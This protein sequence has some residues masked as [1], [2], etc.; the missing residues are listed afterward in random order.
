MILDTAINFHDRRNSTAQR[1]HQSLLMMVFTIASHRCF[2][3][4]FRQ[5]KSWSVNAFGGNTQPKRQSLYRANRSWT[6]VTF[7]VGTKTKSSLDLTQIPVPVQISRKTQYT[8]DDSVCR[9]TNVHLLK[10]VV[11]KACRS[12]P[13]YLHNKP[14]A[15]H[16]RQAFDSLL[17]QLLID[18]S[19]GDDDVCDAVPEVILSTFP[20]GIILD[21]GC[22]T[23]RSTRLLAPMYPHHLIL[24]ID[25]SIA[26]LMKSQNKK[27]K[28][29]Q[30][31]DDNQ[32]YVHPVASNA[33][34][35]RAELV[36]FWRCCLDHDERFWTNHIS[37]HYLL[38]PN[39]YPTLQRL[40]LRWYAH[41]S[42][43]LLLQLNAQRL[44]VRSN[45]EEYLKEFCMAVEIA[46]DYYDTRNDSHDLPTSM[47]TISAS[48]CGDNN[49]PALPYVVSAKYGPHKCHVQSVPLTNFEAKYDKVG[50]HTFELILH[51]REEIS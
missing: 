6:S 34:L 13:Q 30:E 25:R 46:S 44:I 2:G 42:F 5:D 11:Q 15:H 36:D 8:I 16:T 45:W 41:P 51:R 48:K 20:G 39:P 14:I 22:G 37:H 18:L 28:R 40:T 47:S 31:Y 23:G 10:S 35:I 38:Y 7:N 1:R 26:R 27:R 33:Y 9:P 4:Y 32:I 3:R 24:G 29:D 43:P 19:I 12:L 49:N 17:Q 50:E 21:S